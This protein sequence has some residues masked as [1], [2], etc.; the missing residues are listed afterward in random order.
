MQTNA[1]AGLGQIPIDFTWMLT[2]VH[3]DGTYAY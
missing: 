3:G 1:I 2:Y